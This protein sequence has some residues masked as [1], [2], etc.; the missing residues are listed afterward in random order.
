MTA[1]TRP[2]ATRFAS[3]IITMLGCAL[4]MPVSVAQARSQR[5]SDEAQFAIPAQPLATALVQF[6]KQAKIQLVTSSVDLGSQQTHGV[7]GR[8]AIGRALETLLD[9]TGLAY[10]LVGDNTVA[11]TLS[12]GSSS[13]AKGRP[14]SQV[15]SGNDI[16]SAQAE[17]AVGTDA[18][19]REPTAKSTQELDAVTVRIPEVLVVG[20]RILNMDIR[21]TRDDTQ[22]YVIFERE[23][24]ERSGAQN[25]EGFLKQRLTMN[26]V[27]RSNAQAAGAVGN[28]SQINLRG[29]GTNQTLILIDGHRTPS[30]NSNG[31][32]FQTDI[33]GIPL[34]AIERIE[35]LPTTASAIYGGSAT[36]GVVNV[37]LRRDYS[38]VE[39]QVTYENAFAG[40][41][42]SRRADLSAGFN[43][44]DG[45]TNILM[46]AS[47]AEA[48]TLE[49][50]DRKFFIDRGVAKR[51]ANNPSAFF[52]PAT[53]PLGATTNIRSATVVGGV[54]QNLTLD[55][56]TPLGS[57]FTSVPTGYAGPASDGGQ[58]LRANAGVYNL[59]LASTT[60]TDSGGVGLLNTP[61]V[62]SAMATI[63]RQF[64]DRLQLFIDASATNNEGSFQ[65]SLAPSTFTIPANAPTNP[66][67]QAI[68]VRAASDAAGDETEVAHSDRRVVA[69]AIYRFGGNWTTGV[70]Y[71]WDRARQESFQPG[72]YTAAATTAVA[73]GTID[74][75]RDLNAFPADFS[76]FLAPP[77]SSLPSDSTLKDVTA[78]AAGTIGRLPGGPMS[79]SALLEHRDEEFDATA[80]FFSSGATSFIPDRSQTIKSA[81]VEARLPWFSPLNAK[82]GLRE[83]ELQLSARHDDYA[84][85]GVTSTI[86]AGSNTPVERA[87][88]DLSSTDYTV[89]L[90]YA[91]VRDIAFRASYGTGFLPPSVTQ[92][93]STPFAFVISSVTD[94]RRGNLAAGPAG[95]TIPTLFGGNPNLGPEESESWSA[96]IVLTPRFLPGFR[97]S[98]DYE[99][100]DKTENIATFGPQ[101]VINNESVM[102]GRVVRDPALRNSSDPPEWAD[103]ISFIDFTTLN[104]SQA[105]VEAF[106]I[107]LDY[108]LQTERFG[109]FELFVIATQQT[110]FKTQ[111][112]PSAPVVE[113]VGVNG[114]SSIPLKTKG[115]AG[116]LWKRGGWTLGWSTQYF[117]SY[118][119]S[120]NPVT[121][122][123]QGGGGRVPSQTYHDAMA[124]YR[125]GSLAGGAAALLAD[126]EVQIGVKNVFD[127]APP[128]DASNASYL[129]SFL[130]DPRLR[131]Y[132]I[133]VR[134]GF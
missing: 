71:T 89:G 134:K 103:P 124:S 96:G 111:I 112:I 42:G 98:V 39:A 19:S 11:I 54:P 49:L 20:S 14:T 23:A 12:A 63:R 120:T 34:E 62:E 7:T 91:P 36:G 115:N 97:L 68:Q 28:S 130:G 53:P 110:H 126:L 87:T 22:P 121:I 31:L 40:G 132:Y 127:E 66:F 17:P 117:D 27:A 58:A 3:W 57:T 85:K 84:V 60:Q 74:V 10:S 16:R 55:D 108:S 56:G 133:S 44:E 4:A 80:T 79:I 86:T 18:H 119:V 70:D 106:D 37:V 109:D 65:R 131:R 38:G 21:R 2:R 105:Q 32:P 83:L 75:L 33:N 69:G 51:Q 122:A 129:Y 116:L 113:N 48:D 30:I 90:R 99:N 47:Y 125:F 101:F 13:E 8:L 128:Y 43:L 104:I 78:R 1:T 93:I 41:A 46:A 76:P 52:P 73:N 45:K 25:L 64:T 35:I 92:V 9:R 50:R 102:P 24:I 77:T 118:L 15:R 95:T 81:Y 82:P 94:P 123:S 72:G 29:L 6:S 67:Q 107:Q 88:N 61:T 100:I 59:A 5:L 114:E 26:T